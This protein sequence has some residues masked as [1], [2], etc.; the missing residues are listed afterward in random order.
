MGD[1][2]W[3]RRRYA[4]LV[5]TLDELGAE[6]ITLDLVLSEP[7]SPQ[8][9]GLGK[10]YDV[11]TELIEL[12]DRSMDPIIYDDDELRD[13][14]AEAGN[15]YLAMFFR[16]SPP[17]VDPEAVLEVGLDLVRREPGINPER[18]NRR[19]RGAFPGVDNTFAGRAHYDEVR[20]AAVLEQDFGLDAA[21]L[22][23]WMGV[24]LYAQ[25]LTAGAVVV[26]HGYTVFLRFRGGR[27]GATC[28]GLLIYL[29]PWGIPIYAAIF[30]LGLLLT[31]YPTFSYS[32]A[33]LCFPFVAWLIYSSVEFIVFS[34]AIVLLPAIKYIPR[35]K[36][37]SR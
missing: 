9:Q 30:G 34:V 31:R 11:D 29:M 18:F 5:R 3:P 37:I 27:G 14:I 26:G 19:L 10:H 4:Q 36:Q 24:P 22:A 25:L 23:R 28:I 32:L 35:L 2:P 6:A 13:A 33:F 7:T 1:W 12:G 17:G 21:A 16:L 15:I 8:P 20:I